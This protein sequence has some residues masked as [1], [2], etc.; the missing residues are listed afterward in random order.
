M[1]KSS[2]PDKNVA[3]KLFSSFGLSVSSSG[4]SVPLK[5]CKVFVVAS[6]PNHLADSFC[7]TV[8]FSSENF[9]QCRPNLSE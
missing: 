1:K 6:S 4:S 5:P 2:I 3:V 9:V 8:R 7:R